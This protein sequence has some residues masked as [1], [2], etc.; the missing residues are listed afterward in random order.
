MKEWA[1]G[2][3]ENKRDL[4]SLID[5][6]LPES[7]AEE[8]E[9]TEA[10]EPEEAS[11]PD[12]QENAAPTAEEARDEASAQE[13]SQ[14]DDPAFAE[15]TSDA[16]E[17]DEPAD[18]PEESPDDE[19]ENEDDFDPYDDYDDEESYIDEEPVDDEESD[20]LKEKKKPSARKQK[21]RKS[22]KKPTANQMRPLFVLILAA[23]VVYLIVSACT[24][25]RVA[26][27]TGNIAAFFSRSSTS[28][29]SVPTTGDGVTGVKTNGRGFVMLT[30]SELL[31]ATAAE[32]DA[33]TEVSYGA[34]SLAKEDKYTLVYDR[35]GMGYA[36]YDDDCRQIC[37]ETAEGQ[38]ISADIAE[39]GVVALAIQVSTTRTGVR[40]YETSGME[41]YNW[42]L[43]EGFVSDLRMTPNGRRMFVSAVSNVD[44]SLTGTLYILDTDYNTE[45]NRLVFA[46][47]VIMDVK[48][49]RHRKVLV[50]TDQAVYIVDAGVRGDANAMEKI[51]DIS[52]RTLQLISPEENGM[53]AVI[54][55]G[56]IDKSDVQM[57]LFS[58]RNGKLIDRVPLSG[59]V[60]SVSSSKYR[61]AVLFSD[62]VETYSGYGVM[63]GSTKIANRYSRVLQ[64]GNFNYLISGDMVRKAAAYG[65]REL[66]LLVSEREPVSE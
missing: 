34:P 4:D 11:D 62:R 64:N 54:T 63:V 41:I 24:G 55:A 47:Q 30:A 22:A 38:I 16:P 36:V 25:G 19:A 59:R 1:D 40:A 65:K 14:H 2:M 57:L 10:R 6:D 7:E 49:L 50:I 3:D 27:V 32:T 33:E 60:K 15:E 44:G 13:E 37:D 23:L 61:V 18:E 66:G 20:A 46:D 48:P 43:P 45:F 17:A 12:V 39:D 51:Y 58:E 35:G 31:Y 26:A 56:A 42:N 53:I 5:E 21:Q 29:F 28:K 52:D 9:S 8:S